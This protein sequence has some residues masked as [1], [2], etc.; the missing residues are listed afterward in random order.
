MKLSKRER[1]KPWTVDG[2]H[3]SDTSLKVLAHSLMGGGRPAGGWYGTIEAAR[4]LA[5][6]GHEVRQ[7]VRPLVK[8]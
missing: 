2:Q 7:L 8:A 6:Q 4:F 5:E 3:H 1:E